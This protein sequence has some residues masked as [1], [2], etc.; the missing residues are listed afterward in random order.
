MVYNLKVFTF[1]ATQPDM[2]V[3]Y[4]CINFLET[5]ASFFN[6][7]TH[8]IEDHITNNSIVIIF[9]NTLQKN[10]ESF[11][12]EK[13]LENIKVFLLPKPS[14]LTREE[15][16]SFARIE[17]FQKL[18]QIKELVKTDLFHPDSIKITEADLPDLDARHLLYLEKLTE[19]A[20]RITC[21][22]TSRQ[23][24]LIEISKEPQ[25]ESQ[26]DIHLT[27]QEIYTIRLI[28]DVLN[29]KEVH[30]VPNSKKDTS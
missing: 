4:A 25:N 23:G 2:E 19:E 18:Q 16:N 21:F 22:Q 8:R 26:A 7:P 6:I 9:G 11:I 1:K 5:P 3:V 27:F 30:L 20:G 15:K 13:R 28:M 24:K 12:E 10:I 29:V 14:Q 17:A